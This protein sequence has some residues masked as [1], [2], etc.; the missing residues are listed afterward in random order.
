M[1]NQILGQ[2]GE[3][4]AEKYFQQRGYVI[5]GRNFQCKWGEIDLIVVKNQCIVFVEVKTRTDLRFGR[6]EEAVKYHKRK[7]LSRAIY[8]YL[9]QTQANYFKF[10]LD[11]LAILLNLKKHR[12]QIRHIPN[13]SIAEL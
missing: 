3:D 10:Q 4:I 13:I 12:A 11:L 9:Q 7:A 2:L 1:S 8:I 6:P 5:L